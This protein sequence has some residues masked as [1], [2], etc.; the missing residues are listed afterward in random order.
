MIIEVMGRNAG[1]IAL[2][3][4]I[5]GGGDMIL[6]PEIPYNIEV[7]VDKVKARSRSGKRFSIIVVSE[8]ARAMNGDTVIRRM[9]KESTDPVR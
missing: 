6:I 9:V 7:L 1:W 3:S 2:Y 4:G 5:A 8:G